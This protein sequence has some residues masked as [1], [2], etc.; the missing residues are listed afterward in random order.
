MYAIN[1][2]MVQP[3]HGAVSWTITASGGG[4]TGKT[5]SDERFY[6]WHRPKGR[7]RIYWPGFGAM[8]VFS[9]LKAGI[10]HGAP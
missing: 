6:D 10:L 4:T 8:T 1:S 2:A 9:V 7:D 3:V 5:S